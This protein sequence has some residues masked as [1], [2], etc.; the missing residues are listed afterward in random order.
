MNDRQED[1]FSMYLKVTHFLGVNAATLAVNPIFATIKTTLDTSIAGITAQ[2]VIAN[3]DYTGYTEAKAAAESALEES[4]LHVARGLTGYYAGLG[5][6][7]MVRKVD[8]TKTEVVQSRDG[9]LNTQAELIHQIADPVKALLAANQVVA[10]DVDDLNTRRLAFLALF[11]VPREK[12]GDAKAA[13]EEI[14]LLFSEVDKGFKD[15][16]DPLM[17]VY[18]STDTILFS[19]YETARMIDDSGGGS[20]SEGYTLNNFTVPANGSVIFGFTPVSDME[21]YIRNLS[22]NNIII[23]TTDGTTGPCASGYNLAGNALYKDV[24]G[25][26]GLNPALPQVQFSNPNT[27]DVLV[28]AGTKDA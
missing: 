17:S 24:F 4:V 12:Q 2:D 7:A 8:L 28:R 3:T 27:E 6:T 13:R 16:L 23:C 5:D 22:G 14:E 9:I 1:K 18:A 11:S 10:A 15:Q 26:L 19:K 21:V 25:G 20:G